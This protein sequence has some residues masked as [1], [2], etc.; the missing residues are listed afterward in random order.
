MAKNAYFG[1]GTGI[2]GTGTAMYALKHLDRTPGQLYLLTL[3]LLVFNNE[4]IF[5]LYFYKQASSVVLSR[6]IPP[7]PGPVSGL[8]LP[9]PQHLHHLILQ[10]DW[11]CGRKKKDK[12]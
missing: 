2:F 5:Q 12:R 10:E 4:D 6:W 3:L 9:Q 7:V 11:V 1:T 8:Q